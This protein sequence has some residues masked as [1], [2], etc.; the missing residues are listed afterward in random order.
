M[1]GEIHFEQGRKAQ[2]GLISDFFKV[3]YGYGDD[4]S[5]EPYHVWQAGLHR[6][7]RPRCFEVLKSTE[8]GPGK[9]YNELLSRYPKSEKAELARKRLTALGS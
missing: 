8:R 3:A 9:M 2:R 4:K 1:M 7:S 6:S 5:P